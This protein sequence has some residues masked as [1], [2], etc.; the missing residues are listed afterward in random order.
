MVAGPNTCHAGMSN[1]TLGQVKSIHSLAFLPAWYL[2]NSQENA[3]SSLANCTCM[4]IQ[5]VKCHYCSYFA[6]LQQFVSWVGKN[7]LCTHAWAWQCP[8]YRK[9]LINVGISTAF[10]CMSN[11]ATLAQYSEQYFPSPI[12]FF[13]LSTHKYPQIIFI[14]AKGECEGALWVQKQ[15][16][17]QSMYCQERSVHLSKGFTLIKGHLTVVSCAALRNSCSYF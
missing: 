5:Y 7:S 10:G 15:F 9:K 17:P 4:G 2:R 1:H 3:F 6:Q 14:N 16:G 13:L 8:W 11:S 12:L